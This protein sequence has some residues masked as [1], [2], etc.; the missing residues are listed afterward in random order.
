M[1][2]ASTFVLEPGVDGERMGR[3]KADGD[4][5]PEVGGGGDV[6]KVEEGS[7]GFWRVTVGDPT[8]A[9]GRG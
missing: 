5:R 4:V 8:E 2:G 1:G 9:S 3:E 6:F 7:G